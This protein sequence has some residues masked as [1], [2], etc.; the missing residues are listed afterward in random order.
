MS[1]QLPRLPRSKW[2]VRYLVSCQLVPDPAQQDSLVFKEHAPNLVLD[3]LEDACPELLQPSRPVTFVVGIEAHGYSWAR[4]YSNTDVLAWV[5]DGRVKVQ[6]LVGGGR[7]Q[8]AGSELAWERAPLRVE[9]GR[10]A[11]ETFLRLLQSH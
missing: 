1:R 11:S 2:Y 3:R 7:E 6:R 9:C 10:N 5:H 8:D 4:W